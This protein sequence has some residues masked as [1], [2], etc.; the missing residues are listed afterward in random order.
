[1]GKKVEYIN[2]VCSHCGKK[3]EIVPWIYRQQLGRKQKNTYCSIKCRDRAEV[4]ENHPNWTGGRYKQGRYIML[5]IGKNKRI[6][7]HRAIM[8][9]HIGRKLEKGEVIHHINGNPHDNRI[10]NLVLCKTHGQHTEK[11]HKQKREKGC[12][13]GR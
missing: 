6:F 8:E 1:M 4:G 5:N 12:F 3:Y 7:E 2:L 9:K 13:A 10:E 11:Y